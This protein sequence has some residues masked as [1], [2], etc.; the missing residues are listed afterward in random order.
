MNDSLVTAAELFVRAYFA[1]HMPKAYHFHNLNH[2]IG[3]V[4]AAMTI[5]ADVDLSEEDQTILLLSAWFHD[6]GYSKV[7][8]GH[9]AVSGQI[10]AGFLR[11]NHAPESM[12]EQVLDC[13]MATRVPQSP[14]SPVAEILC[15]ADLLHL[16]TDQ[17]AEENKSL[18]K[19]I[20][21]THGKKISKKTWRK[22]TVNFLKGHQY[23]TAYARTYIEPVKSANLAALQK[24]G[25][26]K[27]QTKLITNLPPD[28]A[29]ELL[30]NANGTAKKSPGK[31]KPYS[32]ERGVATMFRIMSAKHVSLSQMADSKAN[33][34]ISLNTIVLSIL[35]STLLGKLQF[36][37]YF[38]IPTVIMVGVCIWALVYAI[39]VTRPNVN[40]GVF[41]ED[42]IHEKKV[43][44]LFFGNFFN[45]ELPDYEWGMKEM[46]N[47]N[48]FLYGSMIKDIYFHGKVLA[49]KFHYLR[50]SYN[51]F[52]YG[53][54]IAI[55]AFGIA[56]L[57]GK[58]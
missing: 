23:F 55:V 50:L 7:Y 21:D 22:D 1:E 36:Y 9:E 17:F 38:I 16:G 37:P 47:D 44:L 18:R 40:K 58:H 10:A 33:I 35:V 15:D 54:I 3:V 52:M 14:K 39:M 31:E 51:I 4:N 28:Q 57:I 49:K 6:I 56:A 27:G 46:M 20:M 42:E 43:N 13:I 5:A 30:A 34:M 8:E 11:D 48:D 32:T 25:P 19:E 41:T 53:L 2:T 26:D 12:I 29:T 45:M 24:T